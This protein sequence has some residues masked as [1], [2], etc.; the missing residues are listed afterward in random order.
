MALS[1]S[2]DLKLYSM[3]SCLLDMFEYII[4]VSSY[5]LYLEIKAMSI[6]LTYF[7]KWQLS[8]PAKKI[9]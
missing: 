5:W 3:Q 4:Y 6:I 1:L 8:T 7:F 2:P 9:S